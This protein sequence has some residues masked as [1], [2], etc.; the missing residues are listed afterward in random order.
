MPHSQ[1][2]W[3]YQL[4]FRWSLQS[5]AER[6]LGRCGHSGVVQAALVG[7]RADEDR[8]D[9][10]IQA[11]RKKPILAE[12][13]GET[14]EWLDLDH[15][16]AVHRRAEEIG[17]THELRSTIFGDPWRE[18]DKPG[19]IRRE[20]I[21]DAIREVFS[22]IADQKGFEFSVGLPTSVVDRTSEAYELYTPF[23]VAPIVWVE[24]LDTPRLQQPVQVG[25]WSSVTGIVE[26]VL[27]ELAA[28]ASRALRS[29][30]PGRYFGEFEEDD[31]V[32][33]R[34]AKRTLDIVSLYSKS[35]VHG[36]A[37]AD[38]WTAIEQLSL[39]RYE[40]SHARGRV[41]FCSDERWLEL[42][43]GADGLLFDGSVT[44]SDTRLV[45]KL[46]QGSGYSGCD[47]T[48]A[49]SGALVRGVSRTKSDDGC[50]IEF[51]GR[52]HWRLLFRGQTILESLD[53]L[54]R[55]SRPAISRV[56]LRRILKRCFG[57]DV[58][59]S[60]ELVLASIA[61]TA[62][63]GAL[64]LIHADANS[65]ARR[66][67]DYGM[68]TQPFLPEAEDLSYMC[69]ADGAVFLAP[70]GVCYGFGYTID[71]E[72]ASGAQRSR[73]SRFNS[74]FRYVSANGRK[75]VALVVSVDGTVDVL[76]QLPIPIDR[77]SFDQFL[78]EFVDGD[79][80]T[81]RA[82]YSWLDR[83][84]HCFVDVQAVEAA[85][86][87]V[88]QLNEFP[89]P[90]DG[91]IRFMLDEF[92]PAAPD[93]EWAIWTTTDPDEGASADVWLVDEGGSVDDRT[94]GSGSDS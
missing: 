78:R 88:K 56:E 22:E 55:L 4:H 94:G 11:A 62:R 52:H 6:A 46:L 38:V 74:A 1:H 12:V 43:G 60:L 16:R 7:V 21:R 80:A 23:W 76:P 91:S 54:P 34:A 27:D 28:K 72:A 58:S 25:R 37:G 66:L 32:L 77:S 82:A 51:L 40:G 81:A 49:V 20:S 26:A 83:V 45:R 31:Q 57:S 36:I 17:A 93:S 5:F 15:F 75:C 29:T 79:E 70:D 35:T 61:S 42:A 59:G 92:S 67:S 47:Y 86:E 33:R 19:R 8:P 68:R 14:P 50:F 73:G 53:G 48:L 90:A 13:G 89:P 44:L 41:E 18:R 10:L 39:A 71:G 63:K 3:G 64:V 30:E 69:T 9:A 87:R 84:R 85:N 65:E 2:M 24:R